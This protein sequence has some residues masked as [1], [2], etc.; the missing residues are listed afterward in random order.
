MRH[1]G[2]LGIRGGHRISPGRLHGGSF[3]TLFAAPRPVGRSSPGDRGGFLGPFVMAG[4]S[5]RVTRRLNGGGAVSRLHAAQ[6]AG[7][8][9]R[10]AVA[11]A[12]T[13]V[14]VLVVASLFT[15]ALSFGF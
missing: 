13:G 8:E 5:T 11:Y 6:E 7:T 9:R 15:W 12:A 1:F 3:E 2:G 10:P 14:F 4:G